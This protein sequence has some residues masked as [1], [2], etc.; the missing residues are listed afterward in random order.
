MSPTRSTQSSDSD[1]IAPPGSVWLRWILLTLGIVF[2]LSSGDRAVLPIL[3][4]TLARELGLTNDGYSR[5]VA[6]FMIP[7]TGMYLV[8]GRVV[9]R[10]GVKQTLAVCV[11]TMSLA[12]LLFGTAHTIAQLALA[13]FTLGIAQACVVPTVTVALFMFFLPYRRALAYAIINGVQSCASILCPVLVATATLAFGW[14]WAFLLPALIGVAVTIQWW[15]VFPAETLPRLETEPIDR[16]ERFSLRSLLRI[17]AARALIL[18]RVVSDPFWFFFQYWQT[19][20][21]REKIGLSLADVGKLAW[22][23][24]LVSL[25]AVFLFGMVSDRLVARRWPAAKARLVPMLGATAFAPAAFILPLTHTVVIAIL[26]CALVNAMCS[27]WLS[28]SA[29]FM[30]SLVPRERLASALG[31]TSAFGCVSATVFNVLAGPVIDRF[32][33]RWPFWIGACL[34]PLA[35]CVL[36]RQFPAQ[37]EPSQEPVL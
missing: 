29:V 1:S 35:A 25:I 10:L 28:L 22:I 6:A 33:Y 17:P 16:K 14:R 34:Y 24:P 23:P 36:L 13:Q 19:A 4:S 32:G 3:K 26:L 11:A 30:G 20:F 37:P 8:V 27:V 12:M 31:F 7:Y 21:L 2:A 18:A 5:L 9:G 15:S